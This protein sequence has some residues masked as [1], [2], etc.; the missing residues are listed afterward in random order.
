ML[1]AKL[2]NDF[3]HC[4][5]WRC[6][7]QRLQCAILVVRDVESIQKFSQESFVGAYQPDLEQVRRQSAVCCA[8]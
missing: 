8:L 5:L 4:V 7:R 3:F 2:G 1:F 6:F